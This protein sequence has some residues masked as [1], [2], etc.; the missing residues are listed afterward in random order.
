MANTSFRRDAD[1]KY[2]KLSDPSNFAGTDFGDNADFR[3]T[4]LDGRDFKGRR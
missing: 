4:Q 3:Y 1:F 2:T